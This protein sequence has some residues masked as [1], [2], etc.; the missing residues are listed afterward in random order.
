MHS[1]DKV[2]RR[3]RKTIVKP[4]MGKKMDK[5][6]IQKDGLAKAKQ[7]D[8]ISVTPDDLFDEILSKWLG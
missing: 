3:T 6:G 1:K 4:P 8:N 5:P 7:S 2:K